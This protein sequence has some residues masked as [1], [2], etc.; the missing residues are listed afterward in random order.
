M[1]IFAEAESAWD[2]L[3]LI[4]T[5][6][7]PQLSAAMDSRA[8]LLSRRRLLAAMGGT[9]VLGGGA[10]LTWSAAAAKTYETKRGERRH[11]DVAQG[12][13][14]DL[15][16]LTCVRVDSGARRV[17]VE[18]GRVRVMASGYDAAIHFSGGV[19][20]ARSA[21]FDLE[22]RTGKLETLLLIK[23]DC[24][25]KEDDGR[26]RHL[27]APGLLAGDGT[28]FSRP[29]STTMDRMTA[30]REG[31]AIFDNEPL[32]NAVTLMNRYDEV[33]LDLRGTDLSSLQ[34]SGTFRL[35]DNRKFA[36]ALEM[37]LPVTTRPKG[38]RLLLISPSA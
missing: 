17:D 30:W 14:L 22:C 29:D 25:F 34:I 24:S 6:N 9:A 36:E 4:R 23:G 1:A 32:A 10:M 27:V 12:L 13:S 2:E 7:Q 28:S 5:L 35:G 21:M 20:V 16:V 18:Q 8:P 15:D 26:G 33:Q 19:I 31:R 38:A 37:L 11:V 3:P